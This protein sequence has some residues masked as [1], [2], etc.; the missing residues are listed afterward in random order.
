MH[1]VVVCLEMGLTGIPAKW[2]VHHCDEDPHNND[3]SNLVL[4][5]MSDHMSLHQR[6]LKGATTMA[7]AS[8]LKWVEAH[9]T[10]FMV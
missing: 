3:F 4:L 7:K 6:V 5:M 1:H 8:T 10:P 2:C 9:G